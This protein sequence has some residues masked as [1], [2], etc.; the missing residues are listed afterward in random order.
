MPPGPRLSISPPQA[1]LEEAAGT[2]D[3]GPETE[4]WL[5]D[6]S[7]AESDIECARAEPTRESAV[8]QGRNYWMGAYP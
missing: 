1:N 7:V 2:L 4:S 3:D 5:V 6:I 8:G